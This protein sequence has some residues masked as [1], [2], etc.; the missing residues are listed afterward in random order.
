M[1]PL[2]GTLLARILEDGLPIE[3]GLLQSCLSA[4]KQETIA[5]LEVRLAEEEAVPRDVYAARRTYRDDL[6]RLI[7]YVRSFS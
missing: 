6:K 2:F 4:A 7:A 3:T 5:A 1:Q